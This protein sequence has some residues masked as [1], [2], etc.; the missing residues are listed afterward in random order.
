VVAHLQPI[1]RRTLTEQQELELRLP[2]NVAPIRADPAQL[3][4][5][6]LNLTINARDAM[7]NGGKLLIETREVELDDRYVAMRPASPLHPG[8]S[9]R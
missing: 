3:D 5:V 8:S 2:P 7:P 4:Q 6:L 9:P 1:L